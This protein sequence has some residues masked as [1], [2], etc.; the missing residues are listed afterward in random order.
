MVRFVLHVADVSEFVYHDISKIFQHA[1]GDS[2]RNFCYCFGVD[3]VDKEEIVFDAVERI[4][5]E[6]LVEWLSY[7]IIVAI[8]LYLYAAK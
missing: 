8:A 2:K 3:I 5:K 7:F 4:K 6:G 1:A